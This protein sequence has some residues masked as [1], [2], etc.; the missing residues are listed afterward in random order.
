MK[1]FKA[2][3]DPE[4]SYKWY[5]K[6]LYTEETKELAENPEVAKLWKQTDWTNAGEAQRWGEAYLNYALLT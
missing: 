4:E 6:R 1:W 3:W 5:S 2:R